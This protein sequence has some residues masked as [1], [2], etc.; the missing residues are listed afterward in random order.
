MQLQ[1]EVIS[2]QKSQAVKNSVALKSLGE[3]GFEIKGGG[4]Q[5]AAMMLM[6]IKFNNG[7]ISL[8]FIRSAIHISNNPLSPPPF[9][10]FYIATINA[11]VKFQA[12]ICN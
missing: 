4:Q 8:V 1:K 10:S 6:L 11:H 2:A 5:M 12:K 9:A 3:K 7:F